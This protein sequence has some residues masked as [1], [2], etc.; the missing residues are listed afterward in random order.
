MCL[1]DDVSDASCPVHRLI[2][3]EKNGIKGCPSAVQCSVWY[4]TVVS[5]MDS[6]VFFS[7]L[8]LPVFKLYVC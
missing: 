3:C 1:L 7:L 2:K 5:S 8:R 6:I 4:V